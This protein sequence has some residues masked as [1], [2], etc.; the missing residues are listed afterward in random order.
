MT[1]MGKSKV[2]RITYERF[3]ILVT[4]FPAYKQAGSTSGDLTRIQSFDYNFSHPAI[5]IKAIGS[6]RLITQDLESPIVR[7]PEVECNLSYIFSSGENEEKIGFHLGSDASVLK[8]FYDN[9]LTDD[10]NLILFADS[11]CEHRDLNN[12]TNENGFSGYNVVGFGNAFLKSYNYSAS[13]GSLPTASISYACSNMRFDEYKENDPPTLPSLKL[14]VDNKFSE[15]TLQIDENSFNPHTENDVPGIL[16][17]GVVV[18]ITKNAGEH[19]GAVLDDIDAAIQSVNINLPIER[20]DIYGFGSNY[21][22]DRKL[23]FPIIGS[24]SMD[25]ILTELY[26]GEIDSFFTKGSRYDM[27]ISHIHREQDGTSK[28]INSFKIENAQLKEQTYSQSID[29]DATVSSSFS[30]G[31]YPSGGLKFYRA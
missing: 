25:M 30:F 24:V 19:G 7:Q 22:F 18:N 27:V 31:V 28:N 8:K 3:G 9:Q 11:E 1:L 2:D 23:K 17:G 14:G 29:Q 20:Q 26:T 12:V 15:E 5:D 16:P 4:D 6:D 21:V 10:V 13:V